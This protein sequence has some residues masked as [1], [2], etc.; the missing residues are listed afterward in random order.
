MQLKH[1]QF[2]IIRVTAVYLFMVHV[3]ASEF[4]PADVI[5]TI[6]KGV[7]DRY[8]SSC[9]YLLRSTRLQGELF[10]ISLLNYLLTYLLTY[11]LR[12]AGYYLKI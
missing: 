3:K 12:G 4:P 6:T 10:L 2:I 7:L 1:F 9:L 11:L 5:V 8:S